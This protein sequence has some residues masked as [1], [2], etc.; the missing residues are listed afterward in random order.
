[1]KTRSIRELLILL[2]DNEN[3]FEEYECSGLCSLINSLYQIHLINYLEYHVLE[4]YIKYHRP[5]KGKH[6]NEQKHLNRSAW[7]WDLHKWNPRKAWLESRIKLN[8]P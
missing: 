6:F 5:M 2:R 3:I 4:E 8:N 1:M 7:Y